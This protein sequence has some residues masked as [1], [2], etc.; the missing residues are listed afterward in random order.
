M[1]RERKKKGGSR[2]VDSWGEAGL[3]G[4]GCQLLYIMAGPFLFDSIP[5]SAP[6]FLLVCAVHANLKVSRK[7]LKEF[8]VGVHKEMLCRVYGFYDPR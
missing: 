4:R 6:L 7:K 5:P 2:M 1:E 3:Q 8:A